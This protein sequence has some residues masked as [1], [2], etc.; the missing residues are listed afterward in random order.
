MIFHDP[1]K[2]R[3][4]R[5]IPWLIVAAL[6]LACAPPQPPHL[7][8]GTLLP[9]AKPVAGFNLINDK[10]ESFTLKDLQGH[11]TFAF[12]G[13]TH[14]PDVCPTSLSMLARVMAKLKQQ[15]NLPRLPRGLFVS[16]D[17]ARDTPAVMAKYVKYFD[18][19]F[20]GV[21]GEPEQLQPLTR[22]LGILYAKAAGDS[23]DAGYHID[24]SAAIVLF[25]PRGRF[26]ALFNVPHDAD[27]IASDFM[28]IRN[29][30]EAS[31]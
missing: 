12:F 22:Q 18:A 30:Y 27:K 19:D 14:C 4:A 25:D 8:Q 15:E 26:Y 21:T 31:E 11:W 28:L 16:V 6:L 1:R 5:I 24:H 29:Y 9:K 10:G 3:L 20:V 23:G 17:P 7:Q 13:Y 2:L